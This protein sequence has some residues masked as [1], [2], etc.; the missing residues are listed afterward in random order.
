MRGR[1]SHEYILYLGFISVVRECKI[2]SSNCSQ[3]RW[4]SGKKLW[5]MYGISKFIL[6]LYLN[7]HILIFT[8]F[9]QYHDSLIRVWS[10]RETTVAWCIMLYHFPIHHFCTEVANKKILQPCTNSHPI[11]GFMLSCIFGKILFYK[12]NFLFLGVTSEVLEVLYYNI[13]YMIFF[14]VLK[15]RSRVWN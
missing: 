13:I 5:H 11:S 2:Q 7:L 9:R 3:F 8:C 12:F 15:Y 4:D 6:S 14:N 1:S 10:V